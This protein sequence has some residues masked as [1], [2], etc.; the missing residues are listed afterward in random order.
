MKKSFRQCL[1]PGKIKGKYEE[2]KIERKSK[3]KQKIDLKSMNHIYVLFQ[4]H[5]TYFNSSI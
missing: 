5:L 1:V 3:G 2:K 4:T